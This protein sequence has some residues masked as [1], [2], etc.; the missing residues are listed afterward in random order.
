MPELPEV[1]TI[2]RDLRD[3]LVGE[4]VQAV[5]IHWPRIVA[6]P[7]AEGLSER[8]VGRTVRAVARRGKFLVLRLDEGA[9]IVHLRMTGQIVWGPPGRSSDSPEAPG[10]VDPHVHVVLRM[11]SGAT[12]CYRD[13]RKFGRFYLVEDPESVLG[14]LGLEPLDES[15]TPEGLHVLLVGRRRRLKDLL[16]DQ[17]FLAGLG[18]IYVDE[19]LW[20]A[21]LSPRR[22]AS[23]LTVEESAR[24]YGA[25]RAVLVRAIAA[26]GTT[27]SD[28]RDAL[29]RPGGNRPNLAV[30]GRR[31]EPCPRCGAAVERAVVAGRGT[32]YCPCCQSMPAGGEEEERDG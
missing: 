14:G 2:V 11:R 15:L 16:L 13:V 20:E 4:T 10:C 31:G 25:L 27:F 18:N 17:T 22:V 28:Y 12:L 29:D 19:A 1:E 21:R 7:T 9:L 6:T 26:R 24:L 5:E 30:Y 8:L 3:V 32:H 23:T